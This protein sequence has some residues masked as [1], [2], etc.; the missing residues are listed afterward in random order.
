MLIAKMMITSLQLLLLSMQA[1]T[2][3]TCR[4]QALKT[5]KV[6]MQQ[7][8]KISARGPILSRPIVIPSQMGVLRC[9][10]GEAEGVSELWFNGLDNFWFC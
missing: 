8:T 2:I 10:L 7:Q 9:Y 3:E 5:L 6:F 1:L 4:I